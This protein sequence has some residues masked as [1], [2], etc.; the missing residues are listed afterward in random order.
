MDLEQI[1]QIARNHCSQYGKYA[2]LTGIFKELPGCI[3]GES[4]L[5]II[6][7]DKAEVSL[8]EME[9]VEESE[10]IYS[11]DGRTYHIYN[12]L[13]YEE[14]IRFMMNPRNYVSNI[15]SFN[16]VPEYERN[17]NQDYYDILQYLL[18]FSLHY[19]IKF[20]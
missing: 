20:E 17:N 5:Q 13:G 15:P 3:L 8:N 11:K 10:S 18:E 9:W 1:R 6:G 12:A 4:R 2:E 14:L 19:G 16:W 7:R